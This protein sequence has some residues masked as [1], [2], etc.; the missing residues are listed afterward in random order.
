ML[1]GL[2]RMVERAYK[3]T[4]RWTP[5]WWTAALAVVVIAFLVALGFYINFDGLNEYWRGVA[6][7][8]AAGFLD[9]MLLVIGFGGYEQFR[10][11]N[12]EIGR[13]RERIEDVKRFDDP[14]AQSILAASIRG[15]SRFGLTDIDLRGAHIADFSFPQNGIQ[16]IADSVISDGLYFDNEMRNFARLR[17]VH[18]T[19]VLCDR[20]CFGK[21]NLS[22]GAYEDCTFYGASLVNATFEGAT[23]RWAA[24]KVKADEREWYEQVDISD[25][26]SPITAQSYSPAFDGA[27]LRGCSFDGARLERADFRGALNIDTATFN[28]AT[29]LDTC[30]FDEGMRPTPIAQ[31]PRSVL[32]GRGRG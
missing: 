7:N 28:G 2:G 21:G 16:S 14:R 8:T 20:V 12:D 6:T 22:L 5:P 27:D 19:G 1:T 31:G 3:L 25:D 18:F 9:I 23:L 30:Y 29:G 13:L 24:D 15:L 4:T 11:R 26:G 32:G 17:S 10:R